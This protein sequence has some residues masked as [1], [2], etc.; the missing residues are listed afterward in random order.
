MK[1]VLALFLV[2]ICMLSLVA[3]DKATGSGEPVRSGDVSDMPEIDKNVFGE[4]EQTQQAIIESISGTITRIDED[5]IYDLTEE[6]VK[7]IA[8]IIENGTWHTEGTAECA[9]DCKL[10]IDERT[11]YYH[12]EC[13]TFNDKANNQNLPVT[14][15]EKESINVILAQYITLGLEQFMRLSLRLFCLETDL[16]IPA[17]RFVLAPLRRGIFNTSGQLG[18]RCRDKIY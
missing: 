17:Y 1:R 4:K 10:I 15:E 8:D 5:K 2:L 7:T 12:S 18:P 9:N 13:G 6:E 16:K 11:Y 14:A 3:C